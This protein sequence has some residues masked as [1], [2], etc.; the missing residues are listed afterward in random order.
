MEVRIQGKPVDLGGRKQRAVLTTLLIEANRVVS[1]DRIIDQLWG[2]EPPPSATGSLQA[3]ISNLRRAL[4]PERQPGE[5]PRILVTKAPGYALMIPFETLDA[6]RFGQGVEAARAALASGAPRAALLRLE[7]ALSMWR[8][9]ALAEFETEPF[10]RAEAA[11][12][13]AIRWDALEMHVEAQLASGDARGAVARAEVL[14]DAEPLRERL[15][16]LLMLALYRAGRQADALQAYN[17]AREMLRE[18]L[19]VDPGPELR[20]MQQLILDQSE[21]L[22]WTP[23]RDHEVEVPQLPL[24]QEKPSQ[25][26]PDPDA[27]VGRQGQLQILQT[28]VDDVVGGQSRLVLILGEAGIGKTR[29]AREVARYATSAGLTVAWGSSHSGDAAPAFWPWTQI[30]R[31]LVATDEEAPGADR[32]LTDLVPVLERGGERDH[33]GPFSDTLARTRLYDRVIEVLLEHARVKPVAVVVDDLQWA[34]IPSLQLLELLSARISAAPFLLVGLYRDSEITDS[35][36]LLGTLDTLARAGV[37]HVAL[38]GL[39]E[40]EVGEMITQRT[41]QRPHSSIVANIRDRTGGNPFFIMEVLR[42]ISSEGGFGPDQRSIPTVIPLGVSSVVR[43]RLSRLPE[44]AIP[45]LTVPAVHGRVFEFEVIAN[46]PGMDRD[47]LLNVLEAGIVTSLLEEDRHVEGRFRFA[48]DL[49]RETLLERLSAPRRARIHA[50]LAEALLAV[51]ADR[52]PSRVQQV[53]SHFWFG[54]SA[55]GAERALPFVMAGADVARAQFAYEDEAEHLRRALKLLYGVPAHPDRTRL[56]FSIQTSLGTVLA[57]LE[58]WASPDAGEAFERAVEVSSE[59]EPEIRLT[60]L[61]G[62]VLFLNVRAEFTRAAELARVILKQGR[63]FDDPLWLSVGHETSGIVAWHTGR[64][65][66]AIANFEQSI[67][68]GDKI[69]PGGFATGLQ[70]TRI[71]SRCHLSAT[72]LELGRLEE[73]ERTIQEALAIAG[74]DPYSRAFTTLFDAWAGPY[75]ADRQRARRRGAEL[76]S[77]ASARGFRVWEAFGHVFHG[78][79]SDDP[80]EIR[81][82]I[83]S[84]TQTGVRMAQTVFNALLADAAVQAGRPEEASGAIARAFE[85]MEES[86]ERGFNWLLTRVRERVESSRRTKD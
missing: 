75:I 60:S 72:F 54:A 12:L 27:F 46:V 13:E 43:R 52:D 19:G 84:M 1:L 81:A 42:L 53:A 45:I 55:L 58:G 22:N 48:H 63:A 47:A 56:E 32:H 35:H 83:D 74:D 16:S 57:R 61:W 7:D 17:R 41:H 33:Q 49:V 51:G 2:D 77:L 6:W 82:G 86:G 21:K 10:A 79:G 24:R 50:L 73:A 80:D 34:D 65:T 67:A 25:P 8:G 23:P 40:E 64:L 11:R 20:E 85:A 3:Y 5:R 28:A 29:L 44:A 76:V 9:P 26:E 68:Y 4:E 36:P 18:E 38:T 66:D 59:L 31:Q 62:H 37:T 30:V 78:W 15:W 70:D 39:P 71:A 14:L 69:E